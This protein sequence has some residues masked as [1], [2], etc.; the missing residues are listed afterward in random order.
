LRGCVTVAVEYE[1]LDGVDERVGVLELGSRDRPR[2]G[3]HGLPRPTGSHSNAA[4][5]PL[6][7]VGACDEEGEAMEGDART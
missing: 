5:L 1:R 4:A 6:E 7:R 2:R 3:H